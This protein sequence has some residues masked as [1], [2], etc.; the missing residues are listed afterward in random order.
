[1]L[2]H[3]NLLKSRQLICKCSKSCQIISVRVCTARLRIINISQ[4]LPTKE[5]FRSFGISIGTKTGLFW[6]TTHISTRQ[7]SLSGKASVIV[8]NSA[9]QAK[10]SWR[11]DVSA[12]N[13]L[14]NCV[15]II[16][17]TQHILLF[18]L[19]NHLYKKLYGVALLEILNQTFPSLSEDYRAGFAGNLK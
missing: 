10:T 14:P 1:M 5:Q 4:Q 13:S 9:Y 8:L 15:N 19:K 11:L 12:Y 17:V 18:F 6:P 16:S 2:L 3:T 7:I